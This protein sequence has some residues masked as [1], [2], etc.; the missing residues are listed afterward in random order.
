MGGRGAH[1]GGQRITVTGGIFFASPD[2]AGTQGL[3]LKGS[4]AHVE[5]GTTET[6]PTWPAGQSP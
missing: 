3:G 4:Y 6:A 1:A 5:A 2:D